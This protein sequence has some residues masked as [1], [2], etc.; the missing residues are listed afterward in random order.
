MEAIFTHGEIC[1]RLGIKQKVSPC[2]GH[3]S[4]LVDFTICRRLGGDFL[5]IEN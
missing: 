5:Y 1:H 4:Y 2:D 3:I